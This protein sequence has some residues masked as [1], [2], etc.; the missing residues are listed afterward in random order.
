MAFLKPR[1]D[2]QQPQ[3]QRWSVALD[4][5][6]R[7]SEIAGSGAPLPQVTAAVVD[8]AVQVLGA[9][10]AILML[11]DHRTRELVVDAA[12]GAGVAIPRGKRLPIATSMP[13][14]MLPA[15]HAIQMQGIA[16]SDL[17]SLDPATTGSS[18]AVLAP[19]RGGD[20]IEGVLYIP[21]TKGE[22]F[23]AD[24]LRLAQMFADQVAGVIQR[25]RLHEK[26]EQRS[27]G[28][29]ALVECTRGLLGTL[30]TEA[31][32]H[33]IL[34]G[35]TRLAHTDGGFVCL[36]DPDT[37][38]VSQG[39]FRNIDKQ[40]I[41]AITEAPSV[42]EAVEAG[43][44]TLIPHPAGSKM[45]IG[46]LTT[47]GTRGLLVVPGDGEMLEERS[48]VFRAFAQQCASVLGAS[49]LHTEIEQKETQLSALIM[50]VPNPIVL[51]D[52]QRNIVSMNPAAERL[53][54]TSAAFATGQPVAS[55]ILNQEIV[56]ALSG[57]GLLSSEI[58]YG[59]PV[60]HFKM[61][62]TDV[63]VPGAPFGRLLVMDDITQEREMA[64][65][66]RDFVAMVGH[67]L[68][69]PLT[70]IKGFAKMMLRKIDQVSKDDIKEALDTIDHRA[71]LL[72]R[73][74]EDLLYVG[75][76]ESR[77]ASLRVEETD[78]QRLVQDVAVEVLEAYPQR[79]VDAE[80]AP[81]LVWA[82]DEAKLAL[83]LRHLIDNAV[84]Y[85]DAGTPVTVRA[86]VV[87]NEMRIDVIDKG[88]GIVSSDI[89]HIFER[90]R[91]V[92]GSATREHGGTGVGLYLSAQ[93][94]KIHGGRIWVD[95]T[96]GKGST[97]SLSVPPAAVPPDVVTLQ[98]RRETG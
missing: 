55:A 35:A 34:D 98:S 9:E 56:D 59:T 73:L 77:E 72:E 44:I 90:F 91:Q 2:T 94:M 62:V 61:R 3:Q 11:V 52:H 86:Q 19:L 84:K 95:S 82:C 32:L 50:S 38:G 93:L 45:A 64:Q 42:R 83:V 12:A 7:L 68:R 43:T 67:E 39:V 46:L 15:G 21:S 85:S 92:D 5:T 78:I 74:I 4:A 54:Q 40:E 57:E 53:F 24:D 66:Q 26:A 1:A 47:Q 70:V 13:G 81:G 33:A 76:I 36:F 6:L 10:R 88:R 37:G 87:E 14:G 65:T 41:R 80:I 8:A 71:E 48:Y 23:D 49:E 63:R 27:S 16:A 75:Q 96:W 58:Q 25:T 30:E 22:S 18:T 97:F 60:T 29:T 79:T 20:G 51:V 31:L 17:G 28:L 89:P 69:T